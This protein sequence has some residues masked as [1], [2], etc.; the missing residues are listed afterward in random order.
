MASQRLTIR[1]PGDIARQLQEQSLSE[2][3]TPSQLVRT[4]L[5]EYLRARRRP[6]TAYDV[7]QELG[8]IGCVK[9]A[10]KDLSTNPRY[11]EGFGKGK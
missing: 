6:R 4:A 9:G 11:F 3:Q 7:A 8:L 1:V 5:Q 2:G 10:P